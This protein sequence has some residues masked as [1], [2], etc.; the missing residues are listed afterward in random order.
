MNRFRHS[1]SFSI[2]LCLVLSIAGLA[3]SGCNILKPQVDATRYFLLDSP[4]EQS[5]P[6]TNSALAIGLRR[7]TIPDYLQNTRMAVRKDTNEL[8]FSDYNRWSERLDT[9]IARSLAKAL[10]HSD[11]IHTVEIAPWTQP[12]QH[13]YIID[14]AI[15][16]FEGNA[17]GQVTLVA[18]WEIANGARVTIQRGQ[19]EHIENDW[20]GTDYSAL[21]GKLTLAISA[22]STHLAEQLALSS[23]PAER[24]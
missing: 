23:T 22:L 2:L 17:N 9:G 6:V 18:D 21:A 16:R 24:R 3:H 19:F 8:L 4:L 12:V 5:N 20:N 14:V 15:I 1:N 13:D 10:R 11:L 7:I